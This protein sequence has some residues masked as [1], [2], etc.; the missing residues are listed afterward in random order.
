MLAAGSK[1]AACSGKRY[2]LYNRSTFG[3]L[4][5]EPTISRGF[6]FRDSAL[7]IPKAVARINQ[8]FCLSPRGLARELA[9]QSLSV[10]PLNLREL[11]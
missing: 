2:D 11:D 5:S 8:N 6:T 9:A 4:I 10:A 7:R 1:W 3:I